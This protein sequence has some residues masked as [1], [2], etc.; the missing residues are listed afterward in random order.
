MAD[1]NGPA[2]GGGI[3]CLERLTIKDYGS[4]SNIYR[5]HRERMADLPI[6]QEGAEGAKTQE[7]RL[8]DEHNGLLVSALS[9]F[10]EHVHH[11]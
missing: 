7:A 4:Q 3:W 1:Y 9:L 2:V 11:L 8:A 6:L 10:A 5:G